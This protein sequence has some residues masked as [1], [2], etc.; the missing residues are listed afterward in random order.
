HGNGQIELAETIVGLREIKGGEIIFMGR[1]I[2]KWNVA[3]RRTEGIGY[4][5]ED[6]F[7][8]G[9]VGEMTLKE[10]LV[11]DCMEREPYSHKGIVRHKEVEG[12]AESAI[13]TFNVKAS[14]CHVIMKTLSGGNQ[15]KVVL[16]RTL[17]G[18]PK[19]IIACQPTRGLDFSATQFLRTKLI[20]SAQNNL[21]V[22]LVSSDLDELMELSDRI[23]V[24][25]RGKIVGDVKRDDVDLQKLGLM[26][27]GYSEEET[28]N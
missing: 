24:M 7:E 20:E 14:N 6:R 9:M 4:I 3:K 21:G 2:N 19:V 11:L 1:N 17:M 27:A 18:N 12:V 15:Q 16:A 5:P 23:V 25:F 26:M 13:E 22:L 8:K 28:I 10:N